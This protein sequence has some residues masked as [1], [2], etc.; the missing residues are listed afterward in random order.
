[1]NKFTRVSLVFCLVA[2]LIAGQ[3]DALL[4]QSPAPSAPAAAINLSAAVITPPAP[5]PSAPKAPAL[6]PLPQ[7][8]ATP[9]AHSSDTANKIALFTGLAMTGVGVGLLARSEPVH[10]TTCVTYGIC[11]VPGPNHVTGGILIGVGVPLTI[12]SLVRH[13]KSQ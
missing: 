3:T 2:F 6:M 11:P 9:P 13:K 1:M 7:A 5:T 10:Q 12:L 4:A 8:P